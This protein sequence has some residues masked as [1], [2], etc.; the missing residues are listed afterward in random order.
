MM[1]TGIIIRLIGPYDGRRHDMYM[2]RDGKLI[3][4][5]HRWFGPYFV[6]GDL[7]Y[8]MVGNLLVGWKGANL[9]AQQKAFNT[10]VSKC[11][12]SVEH[13]FGKWIT[14]FAF[15]NFHANLKT[16]LQI[17]GTIHRVTALLTNCHTCLYGHQTATFY[18][19]RP[20]TLEEYLSDFDPAPH[21]AAGTPV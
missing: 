19:V 21:V 16:Q 9:S 13:G 4:L 6:Y 1:C 18:D 17:V 20:P 10:R 11:R 5:L 12:M 3:E 14:Q 8:P 2:I 7:G 15:I